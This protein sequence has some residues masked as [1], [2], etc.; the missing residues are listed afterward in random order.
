MALTIYRSNRVETLQARLAERLAEAPLSHP[1]AAETIVVPTHAM[2]RWLNLN[3]ARQQGIAANLLYPQPAEW[4]WSL[5]ANL[6]QDVPQKD[7]CARDALGWSI[8]DTLPGLLEQAAFKPLFRYLEDDE[9]GIKRWQ[10][11][12]RVADCFDR[13]QSCRPELI[14]AW[15]AGD[16]N[17][18]QAQLWRQIVCAQHLPHRVELMQRLRQR[19]ADGGA[20]E[21]LPER[22]SLF[23]LSRLAPAFFEVIH[24]LAGR[25]EL[26]LFQHNPTDQYWAD[27]V[28][29]KEQARKRLQDPRQGDYYDSGNHLL[30]SWGRQGQA[31][32]DLLL[33][34]GPLTGAEI[35]DNQA[36]ASPSLLHRSLQASLFHLE[37]PR[38]ELEARG[39]TIRCHCSFAIARYAN[40]RCCTTGYSATARSA[41]R[42]EQ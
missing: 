30:T 41:P 27:L 12:L 18:W 31:M 6:L 9:N 13:Y 38:I 2:A 22:V 29:E 15:S 42:A 36:P 17:G 4:L 32:Q 19:L 39:S 21:A 11:S 14:R 16:D 37:Q 24:A 10:L 25:C 26:L 34:L 7:P 35:E 33:D 20:V 23:A 5:A 28:S 3:I 8:F 40:A 1:F